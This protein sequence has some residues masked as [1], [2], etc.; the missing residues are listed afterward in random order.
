MHDPMIDLLRAHAEHLDAATEPVRLDDVR[1]AP[2]VSLDLEPED[3][4]RTAPFADL[5]TTS[6]DNGDQPPEELEDY[7]QSVESPTTMMRRVLIG[8]GAA[9]AVILVVVLAL[10]FTGDPADETE[11]DVIS[12]PDQSTEP[13]VDPATALIGTWLPRDATGE[14]LT[15]QEDDTWSWKQ[16]LGLDPS[17][18]GVYEFEDGVLTLTTNAESRFCPDRT[19]IYKVVFESQDETVWT[20]VSDECSGRIKELVSETILRYMP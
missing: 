5:R 2:K 4:P 12:E 11:L 17:D 13:V 1:V 16:G 8:A 19:G 15:F 18:E 6:Q 10:S 9:A 14:H 7:M 20:S 3:G